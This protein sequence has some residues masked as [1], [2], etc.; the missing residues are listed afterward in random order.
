MKKRIVVIVIL[1]IV[2]LLIIGKI[3]SLN[4]NFVKNFSNEIFKVSYDSSWNVNKTKKEFKL[5]HKKT[6]SILNIQYK[7]LG[8]NYI[9]I[10]LKDLIS[11][12]IYSIEKQNDDYKLINIVENNK[13]YESYSY[14]YESDDKQVLVNIYKKNTILLIAYYEADI[15]YFDIV[16]DSVD[17]ILNSLEIFDNKR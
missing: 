17:S 2:S 8:N 3:C 10:N 9:N 16:L 1:M 5:L 6:N 11:E 15:K 4:K 12:I 13:K 14:L 7:D